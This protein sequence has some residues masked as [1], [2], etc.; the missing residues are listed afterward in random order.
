MIT[1]VPESTLGFVIDDIGTGRSGAST[2][3]EPRVEPGRDKERAQ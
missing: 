3:C 1:A 2:P